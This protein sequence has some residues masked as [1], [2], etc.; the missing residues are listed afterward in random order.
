MHIAACPAVVP[1]R[2]CCLGAMAAVCLSALAQTEEVASYAS[3]SYS[4]DALP[5]S[6]LQLELSSMQVPSLNRRSAADT[7]S[8]VTL[9]GWSAPVP[10]GSGVGLGLGVVAPVNRPLGDARTNVPSN[11]G[12]LDL[13]LRWRSSEDRHGGR[14]HVGIWQRV[15][16]TPDAISLIQQQSGVVNNN[17]SETRLE[18]QFSAASARGIKFELGGAL[19]MQL[20][21]GGDKVVLRVS[22]GRPMV[23]YRAKF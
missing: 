17:S 15:T 21:S 13:G 6:N 14:M 8:S 10:Q 16:P 4:A 20:N 18:M 12:G 7:D 23:Y 11:P 5:R 1:L 22:H 3:N 9:T 2:S 19:G